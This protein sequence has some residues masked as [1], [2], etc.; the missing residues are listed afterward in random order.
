VRC[1]NCGGKVT[2]G[3]THRS[4]SADRWTCKRPSLATRR[5]EEAR[6]RW[7]ETDSAHRDV[8]YLGMRE[9]RAKVRQFYYS[10]RAW[11]DAMTVLREAAKKGRRR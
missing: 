1:E 3:F 2:K 8:V 7:L 4:P 10:D 6:K 5:A 9:Q 11:L